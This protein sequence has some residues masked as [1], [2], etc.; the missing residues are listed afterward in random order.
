MGR[1]AAKCL[2]SGCGKQRT[3]PAH[4]SQLLSVPRAWQVTWIPH[5]S[6]LEPRGP[7][8]N[9]GKRAKSWP[10]NVEKKARTDVPKQRLF[11]A[12]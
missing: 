1:Q 9:N 3:L 5:Q 11:P 6:W 12:G 10:P 2:A 8:R 7:P 4:Q